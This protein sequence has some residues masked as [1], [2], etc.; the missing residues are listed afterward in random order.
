MEPQRRQRSK[1]HYVSK[2][3]P[4]SYGRLVMVCTVPF[5]SETS[6][7]PASTGHFFAQNRAIRKD[8]IASEWGG[9]VCSPFSSQKKVRN[10]VKNWPSHLAYMGYAKPRPLNS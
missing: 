3:R 4:Y 5:Q 10:G 1:R 2:G 7:Y 6:K 9:C 8:F